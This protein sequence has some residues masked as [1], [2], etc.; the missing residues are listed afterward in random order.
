MKEEKARVLLCVVGIV[1]KDD[2]CLMLKR[3]SP[4]TFWVPPCGGVR[5]GEN[6]IDALHREVLEEAGIKV[7]VGSL[8]EVW[9]GRHEEDKE[10]NVFSV[11]YLCKALTHDVVISDEHEDYRWVP[12]KELSQITTDFDVK[13]WPEYIGNEK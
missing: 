2:K 12:I 4:S 8:V 13:K 6:I 11:T 9:Q 7:K 1:L 5:T 3:P 10:D